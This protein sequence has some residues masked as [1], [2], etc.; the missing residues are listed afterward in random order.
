MADDVRSPAKKRRKIDKQ[1][2]DHRKK[3]T[4][5]EQHLAERTGKK[6]T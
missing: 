1:D 6:N 2:L 5:S 3:E 4:K